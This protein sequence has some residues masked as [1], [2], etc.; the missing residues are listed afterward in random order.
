MIIGPVVSNA[1]PLIALTQIDHL[2]ILQQ[3]CGTVLVPP[4]VTHEVAPTLTI[5]LKVE[6]KKMQTEI[7]RLNQKPSWTAFKFRVI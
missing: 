3:L 4:A 5:G 7:R 1:S 6:S 2:T